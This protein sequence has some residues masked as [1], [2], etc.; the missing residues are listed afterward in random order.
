MIIWSA[1]TVGKGIYPIT[2]NAAHEIS[3]TIME[4]INAF[5]KQI[6]LLDVNAQKLFG[7]LKFWKLRLNSHLKLFGQVLQMQA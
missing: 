7:Y 3:N 2:L 6:K 4:D 1:A 5:K